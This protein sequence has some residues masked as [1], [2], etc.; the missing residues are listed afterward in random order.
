MTSAGGCSFPSLPVSLRLRLWVRKYT[1]ARFQL[2]HN[3]LFRPC[4]AALKSA[5]QEL[6]EV[7]IVLV[8]QKIGQG[9]ADEAGVWRAAVHKL[10]DAI[11]ESITAIQEDVLAL[12]QLAV[13]HRRKLQPA[14]QGASVLKHS[15]SSRSRIKRSRSL[16]DLP[17]VRD[18]VPL[19]PI[20]EEGEGSRMR[21]TRTST[22]SRFSKYSDTSLQRPLK[23]ISTF[24]AAEEGRINAETVEPT[25]NPV[26]DAA[27]DKL[28]ILL[29]GTCPSS[30]SPP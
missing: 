2:S 15:Q 9:E 8:D 23:T 10:L 13:V 11:E 22:E 4:T 25:P 16:G 5:A 28:D 26:L 17:L 14:M 27:L 24:H 29:C 19:M 1:C 21:L 30:P 18:L 6:A 20:S 12:Q 3:T 7:A